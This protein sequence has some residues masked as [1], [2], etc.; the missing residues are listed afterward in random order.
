MS[1]EA[2]AAAKTAKLDRNRSALIEIAD[3]GSSVK[4]VQKI[5][6]I[7]QRRAK[8]KKEAKT[9]QKKIVRFPTA[10]EAEIMAKLVAFADE[11]GVEVI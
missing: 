8:S 2:V 9:F 6:E 4:Q 3:A 1:P 11:L 7:K 10:R 5:E